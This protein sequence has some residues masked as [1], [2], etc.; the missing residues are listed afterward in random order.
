MRQHWRWE[1]YL[2]NADRTIACI[3]GV[4]VG[5]FL[6]SVKFRERDGEDGEDGETPGVVEELSPN[7]RTVGAGYSA[8]STPQTAPPQVP[9]VETIPKIEFFRRS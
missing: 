7:K 1:T 6:L 4:K 2:Y 5:V 9:N 8:P 3:M